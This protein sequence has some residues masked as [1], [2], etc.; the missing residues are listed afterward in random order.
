MDINSLPA[1][2]SLLVDANIVIYYLAGASQ[3]C[4]TFFSRVANEEIEPSVTT[5]IV[6]EVLHRRMIAADTGSK[7][8]LI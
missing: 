2:T 4:K 3:D 6:A 1:G 5:T 8:M 7:H